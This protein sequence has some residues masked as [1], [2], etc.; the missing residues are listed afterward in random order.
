MAHLYSNE[1][2][3]FPVVEELRLLGHNVLTIQE[4]GKSGQS[5]PDEDF[6]DFATADRR[7]VLTLNRKHFIRMHNSHPNHTG[8]IV[9]TFDPDFIGQA[10]RIN[11]ALQLQ[12]NLSGQLI[13][14]N[15]PAR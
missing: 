9:C 4:T 5:L 10:R 11:S 14:V 1:N 3:P 12:S 15:R 13:R 8:I 7:A 2:F 6:L